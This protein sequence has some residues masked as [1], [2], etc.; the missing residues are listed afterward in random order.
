MWILADSKWVL[1]CAGIQEQTKG[2]LASMPTQPS[3]KLQKPASSLRLSS[4]AHPSPRYS[5]EL[6]KQA[7]VVAKESQ[8]DTV[9]QQLQALEGRCDE[10]LARNE[11]LELEVMRLKSGRQ[12]R[13]L[14]LGRIPTAAPRK[15]ASI[16]MVF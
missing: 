3:H 8:W 5:F 7:L 4:S 1:L 2:E 15:A 14:Q 6:P 11:A 16:L 9:Q 10:L 12:V 13:A